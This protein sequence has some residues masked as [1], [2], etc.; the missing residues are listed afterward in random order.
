MY[1]TANRNRVLQL[2]CSVQK[3]ISYGF[4]NQFETNA[5][6]RDLLVMYSSHAVSGGG[7]LRT[8]AQTSQRL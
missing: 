6:L 4:L 2:K 7:C 1:I 5:T 8:G 3:L